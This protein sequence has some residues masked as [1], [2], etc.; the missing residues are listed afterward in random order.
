MIV[1]MEGHYRWCWKKL[2]SNEVVTKQQAARTAVSADVR[3]EIPRT[4]FSIHI[5]PRWVLG[6]TSECVLA[7][8]HSEHVCPRFR[9][10]RNIQ[11]I[12]GA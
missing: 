12:R 11:L 10:S 3:P 7:Q 5:A 1:T 2:I 6:R 9:Q 4:K 8:C